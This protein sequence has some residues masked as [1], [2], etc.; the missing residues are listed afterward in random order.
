MYFF[1]ARA[2]D[3]ILLFPWH[4]Y[5]LLRQSDI[6]DMYEKVCSLHVYYHRAS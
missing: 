4:K 2:T 5:R 3:E 1:R 6:L